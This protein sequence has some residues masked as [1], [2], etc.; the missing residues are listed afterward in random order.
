VSGWTPVPGTTKGDL[1]QVALAEF[2]RRGFDD[3]G[4]HEIAKAAGVTIGSLYHHFGSKHGLYRAARTDVE[5]RLL[6]RMEGARAALP[7]TDD[8]AT[9]LEVG[10]EYVVAAGF[11]RMLS[12]RSPDQPDDP[13]EEFIVAGLTDTAPMVGRLLGAAWRL[14]LEDA[15]SEPDAARSALR[16]VFGSMSP[17]RIPLDRGRR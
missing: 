16:V 3:V 5:R 10:F 1:I 8:L 2:G 12:E 15:P 6:D 14:A 11:A 9:P 7:S 4:V 17:E 13:I